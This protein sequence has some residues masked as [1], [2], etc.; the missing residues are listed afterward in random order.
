MFT[1]ARVEYNV[2][3]HPP[4]VITRCVCV[5]FLGGDRVGENTKKGKKMIEGEGG[6]KRGKDGEVQCHSL[7]NAQMNK[8]TAD[9][10]EER[11]NDKKEKETNEMKRM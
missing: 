7:A 1:V 4:S 10:E 11:E 5:F 3:R 2:F 8:R 6:R 9:S